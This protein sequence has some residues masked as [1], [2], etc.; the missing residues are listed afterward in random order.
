MRNISRTRLRGGLLGPPS[1]P[2]PDRLQALGQLALETAVGGA[3]VLALDAEIVLGRY[4]VGV[5]VRVLVVGAVPQARGARVMRVAQM[6]GDRQHDPR[7]I[8]DMFGQVE[9]RGCDVVI[10]SR[11]LGGGGYRIGA[12]KSAGISVLRTIVRLFCG[13]KITDPTSGYQCL[14]RKVFQTLTGDSFP[15]DYPDANIIILYQKS[16]FSIKEIPVVMFPNPE[17]RSMHQGV[18]TVIYYFFKIFL[19]IFVTLIREK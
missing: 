16:G 9:S 2:R 8:P 3:V 17:G 13:E 6:D 10:G 1:K 5:V 11:F 12:L 7:T 15:G 4:P 14:S 18:F 19:S